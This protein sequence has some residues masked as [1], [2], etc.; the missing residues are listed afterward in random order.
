MGA[1]NA[2]LRPKQVLPNTG[3][4]ASEMTELRICFGDKELF[5]AVSCFDSNLIHIKAFDPPKQGK[6]LF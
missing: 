4:P 6:K 3:A 2:T 1:H 5:I